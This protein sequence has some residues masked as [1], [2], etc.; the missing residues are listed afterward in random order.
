MCA[1]NNTNQCF[2]LVLK[3]LQPLLLGS[4]PKIMKMII[5]TVRSFGRQE[6]YFMQDNK[7]LNIIANVLSISIFTRKT[8]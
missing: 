7:N 3:K 8:G 4:F 2:L 5:I 6:H 1:P